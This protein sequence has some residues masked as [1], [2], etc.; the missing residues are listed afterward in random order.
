METDN[1]NFQHDHEVAVPITCHLSY[2]IKNHFYFS[3]DTDFHVLS[4]LFGVQLQ[5]QAQ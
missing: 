3:L 4:C 1:T 2:T 5:I